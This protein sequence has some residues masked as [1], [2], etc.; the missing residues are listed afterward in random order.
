MPFDPNTATLFQEPQ[1]SRGF[2][3]AT[4][5]LAPEGLYTPSVPISGEPGR[6]APPESKPQQMTALERIG[7]GALDPIY[8]ANQAASHL[9]APVMDPIASRV[10]LSTSADIDRGVQQREAGIKATTPQ[11][12]DWWRLAG[13]VASP[14]N[15]LVPEAR[16]LGVMGKAAASG[17][18]GAAEQP[19]TSGKDYGREKSR[20][21]GEGA[22]IGGGM[23]AAGATLGKAVAP[24]FDSAV[25]KL[26]DAGVKLTPGQMSVG[27]TVGSAVKRTESTASSVPLVGSVVGAAY[28]KTLESFNRAVLDRALSPL[29]ETIPKNV[30]MGRE[31]YAYVSKM[32]GDK[33]NDILPKLRF[34]ADPTFTEDYANLKNMVTQLPEP[35]A[36]QFQKFTQQHIDRRLAPNGQ[37]DGETFKDLESELSK[38][39]KWYAKSTAPVDG[40]YATA[41]QETQSLLRKS[42]LRAN[43]EYAPELSA[44]NSTY[45]AYAR[46]KDASINRSGSGGVFSPNDLLTSI[47]H[48]ATKGQ[49]STGDAL[50]QDLADAGIKVLPATV[51]NSGTADRRMVGEL[52]A[53]GGLAAL[54]G[55]PG[56]A[57]GGLGAVAPYTDPGLAALQQWATA[58]PE[59]REIV[60]QFLDTLT[61]ALATGA[62]GGAS[63]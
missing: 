13:N 47:K 7:T 48:A 12:T 11:G 30:P 63:R 39:I 62:A 1:Q 16:G 5:Q 44:L 50:L 18:L 10:G 28:R 52:L 58:A 59:N 53:G 3:P 40:K 57:L 27:G 20:Q 32:I 24:T 56:A 54:L 34:A 31:A 49:F 38:E 60:R 22:A 37:M 51:P 8:G 6:A 55:H 46:A 14:M 21:I 25:K 23:G 41:L 35:H 9:L 26:L 33:Y 4:A 43:P 29:G 19:V 15:A 61:P 2:D 42:L 45:A 36:S 17:A